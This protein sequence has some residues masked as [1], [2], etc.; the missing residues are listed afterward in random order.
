MIYPFKE[1]R[2]KR[3]WIDEV[4]EGKGKEPMIK[5]GSRL[6]AGLWILGAR[7]RIRGVG[8]RRD[9]SG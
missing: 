1:F 7:C 3:S 6:G 5:C 4:V 9:K 2:L 8:G